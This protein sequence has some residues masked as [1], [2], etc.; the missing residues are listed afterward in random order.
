MEM[1]TA[2]FPAS[3]KSGR[4]VT[5]EIPPFPSPHSTAGPIIVPVLGIT[6]RSWLP[7]PSKSAAASDFDVI[8]LQGVNSDRVTRHAT[9]PTGAVPDQKRHIP[10]LPIGN[11]DVRFAVTGRVP[12]SN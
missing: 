6:I 1:S 7:S 2:K 5:E 3:P 12:N 8:G 4:L 10:A 11:D 9:E